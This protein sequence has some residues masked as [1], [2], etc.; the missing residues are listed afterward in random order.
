MLS[1]AMMA[2]AFSKPARLRPE[3]ISLSAASSWASSIRPRMAPP[4]TLGM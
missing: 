4:L 3:A 1:W 2:F